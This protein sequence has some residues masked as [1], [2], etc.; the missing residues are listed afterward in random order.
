MT[1][2]ASK[3]QFGFEQGGN[4]MLLVAGEVAR[5]CSDRLKARRLS[6]RGWK[7][8]KEPH[9]GVVLERGDWASSFESALGLS[10]NDDDSTFDS[11]LMSIKYQRRL[12][13]RR[14]KVPTCVG[15]EE[16]RQDVRSIQS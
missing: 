14:E 13:S 15:M 16:C 7:N 6:W 1:W 10:V 2:Q 5:V 8:A 11:V 12:N 4:W 9:N 3:G